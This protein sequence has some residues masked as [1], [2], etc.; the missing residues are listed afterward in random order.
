V[1]ERDI[2]LLSEIS[3]DANS[4]HYIAKLVRTMPFGTIIAQDGICLDI[5]DAI[6]AEDVPSLA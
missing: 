4:L 5:L 3:S 6:V 1:R 2:K